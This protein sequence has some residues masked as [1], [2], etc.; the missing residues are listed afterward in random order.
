[1]T[2]TSCYSHASTPPGAEAPLFGPCGKLDIELELGVLLGGSNALGAPVSIEQADQMIFGYVLLNDWSARDIQKWEYVPLGPFLGKS[3]ATSISPW[4]VT[5]D[6]LEPFRCPGPAQN[7]PVPLAY[8]S[9]EEDRAYDINLEVHLLSDR[10]D[11][12]ARIA[13]SNFRYMYWNICQQL[14][15]HTVNGCNVRPGDLMASGTISGPGKNERGSMLEILNP[16]EAPLEIPDAPRPF[17]I[18]MIGVNGSGKTTTIGKLARRFRDQG[19]QVMLAAGDTFRAAAVEQL[20]S[21][22]ERLDVP[23]ISQG[24]GADAASPRIST[25]RS[26]SANSF[27]ARLPRRCGSQRRRDRAPR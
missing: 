2:S 1:M 13:T 17:V 21:W 26:I 27:T 5:L 18:L 24:Q 25:M 14:A 9:G 19:L 11:R 23:V 7:D 12:P 3:F 22:G 16:C 4:V 20:Q 6:A 10:M 8:L 15:H